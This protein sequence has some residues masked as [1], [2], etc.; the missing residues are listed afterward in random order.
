MLSHIPKLSYVIN[1]SED[2]L[3]YQICQGVYSFHGKYKH[4]LYIGKSININKRIKSHF[5]DAK[6][7]QKKN[8]MMKQVTNIKIYVIESEFYS[9]LIRSF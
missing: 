5:R 9:L 2:I 6:I 3:K 4:P 8:N 7:I 1:N